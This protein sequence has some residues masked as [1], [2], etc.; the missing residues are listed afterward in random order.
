[1]WNDNLITHNTISGNLGGVALS[2]SRQIDFSFNRIGVAA[3]GASPCQTPAMVSTSA[4]TL[5]SP[6]TITTVRV[7]NNTIAN[8]TGGGLLIYRANAANTVNGIRLVANA[9]YN[10]TGY[11]L[12]LSATSTSDG[13]TMNDAGDSDQALTRCRMLPT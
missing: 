2:E 9:L 5:S 3:D 7:A 10:N 4:I 13:P 1:M 11:N 8:N 12:D 6:S